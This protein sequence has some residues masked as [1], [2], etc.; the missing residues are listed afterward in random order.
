MSYG[1]PPEQVVGSSAMTKD[2]MRPDGIPLLLRE[3]KI[4]F[5]DDKAGKT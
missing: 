1:I 2:Q 3:R 4:E 5:V